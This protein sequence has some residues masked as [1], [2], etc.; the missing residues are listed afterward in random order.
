M[1]KL[2]SYF[3]SKLLDPHAKLKKLKCFPSKDFPKASRNTLEIA[4]N[5]RCFEL[6][7]LFCTLIL[8]PSLIPKLK[9][10]VNFISKKARNKVTKA[11][12]GNT[13]RNIG[14]V[15]FLH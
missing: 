6:E 5:V 7:G 15:F 12:I 11:W 10:N 2:S 1:K 9:K 4:E 14:S 3:R 13:P 8:F